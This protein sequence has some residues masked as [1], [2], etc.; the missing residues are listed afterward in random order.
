MST[1][2]GVRMPDAL[3]SWQGVEKGWLDLGW[4]EGEIERETVVPMWG[5]CSSQRTGPL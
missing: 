1:Y 2:L 4:E 5:A 3:A